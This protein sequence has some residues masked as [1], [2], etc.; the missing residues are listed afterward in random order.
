MARSLAALVLVVL[1]MTAV[2]ARTVAQGDAILMTAAEKR[3]ITSYFQ[4]QYGVWLATRGIG[5]ATHDALPP[6]LM[7][8]DTLAPGQTGQLERNGKLPPGVAKHELPD[9]LLAQLQPR[10][11]GYEFVVVG[12]RVLLIQS[13]TDLILDTLTVAAAD[14]G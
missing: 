9:D 11:A 13:A 5:K 7:K 2:T 8:K 6:A 14:A 10:P 3:I 1:A 12:D 4:R